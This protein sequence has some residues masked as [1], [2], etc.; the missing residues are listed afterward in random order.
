MLLLIIKKPF[1]KI[2]KM[3]FPGRPVSCSV[4]VNSLFPMTMLR[5]LAVTFNDT[6]YLVSLDIPS[7]HLRPLCEPLPDCNPGQGD[8]QSDIPLSN[9]NALRIS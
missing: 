7:D 9:V 5:T 6:E 8:D 2:E 3:L 1:P 4:T